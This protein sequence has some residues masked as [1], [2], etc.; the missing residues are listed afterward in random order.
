M[1]E[2]YVQHS[3]EIRY[4]ISMEYFP[5]N[6]FTRERVF[7]DKYKKKYLEYK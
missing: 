2:Y 4:G 6:L 5:Q 3:Y 1:Q 7:A